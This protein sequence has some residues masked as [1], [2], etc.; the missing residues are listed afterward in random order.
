MTDD[1]YPAS[2]E[3][4]ADIGR[5]A[6]E[7]SAR[8]KALG[9]LHVRGLALMDQTLADIRGRTSWLECP[10]CGALLTSGAAVSSLVLVC[11]CERRCRVPAC[12]G[13]RQL[14]GV[15]VVPDD[16]S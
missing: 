12:D 7:M 1:G 6:E 16:L 11:T 15:L 8:V 5:L 3:W 4:L 9:V 2:P 10:R 13:P 14:H